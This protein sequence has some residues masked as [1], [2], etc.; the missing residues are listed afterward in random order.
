MNKEVK[1]LH[2]RASQ[3]WKEIAFLRD[4]RECQVKKFFPN[5][6]IRHS[7][8]LQVDHCITRAN[9]HLFYEPKNA[10][11]VCSTCNMLKSVDSKSVGRAIDEIVKKREGEDEFKLMVNIDAGRSANKDFNKVWWLEDVIKK[12]ED[13]KSSIL[14][15]GN[16]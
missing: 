1:K 12:L 15:E 14:R 10:T 7:N 11:V 4:G 8:I 16:Y 2:E 13:I 5:I 3:L 9:K 6:P